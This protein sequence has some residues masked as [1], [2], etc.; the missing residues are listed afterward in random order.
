MVK[1]G[2]AIT[3]DLKQLLLERFVHPV[4]K[5]VQCGIVYCLR[6]GAGWGCGWWGW[7]VVDTSSNK[8]KASQN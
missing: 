6:W 3:D 1:K 4:K 2:K 7:G 8:T 5:R